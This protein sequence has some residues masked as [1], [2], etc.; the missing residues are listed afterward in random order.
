VHRY[1]LTTYRCTNAITKKLLFFLL[2]IIF[3]IPN[4]SFGYNTV[5]YDYVYEGRTGNN[6]L[7]DFVRQGI[8]ESSFNSS[9][10]IVEANRGKNF[11]FAIIQSIK[12]ESLPAVL[13]NIER[14]DLFKNYHLYT[15]ANY[16]NY[17]RNLCGYEEF[18]IDL[19]D[20]I[21]D[22]RNNHS[23]R[24]SLRW[25]TG[26]NGKT[27]FQD[28]IDQEYEK[29]CKKRRDREAKK[30]ERV[31]Q[32]KLAE[33]KFAEMNSSA[34]FR[35]LKL[36][37]LDELNNLYDE[38]E[39]N[40][41]Q[42]SLSFDSHN[43]YKPRL[44]AL[45]KTLDQDCKQFDY[46]K[47]VEKHNF[48]DSN[49]E[50]FDYCYGTMLDKQL[51]EELCS[52]RTSAMDLQK[53][54]SD[55]K[56]AYI[57]S[58]TVLH[59]TAVAK[60]QQSANVAFHLSD[61]SYYFLKASETLVDG[62][63]IGGERFLNTFIHP[64]DKFLKPL[65]LS[66]LALG[67]AVLGVALN[68]ADDPFTLESPI[69]IVKKVKDLSCDFAQRV[70]ENPKE[71]VASLVE[72]FLL[73]RI[74]KFAKLLNVSKIFQFRK[75]KEFGKFVEPIQRVLCE[76]GE[77]LKIGLE[78]GRKALKNV[79]RVIKGEPELVSV[80]DIAVLRVSGEHYKDFEKLSKSV[81]GGGSVNKTCGLGSYLAREAG[82]SKKLMK[83][84]SKHIP[85]DF[86]KQVV[87]MSKKD[88]IT[89]L[90]KQSFFNPNWTKEEIITG[91]TQGYLF[92]KNN[93]LTGSYKHKFKGEY[94]NIFVKPNGLIDTAFGYHKLS[95]D[96]FLK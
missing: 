51:H 31:R 54:H 15:C 14:K 18:I 1:V 8:I 56:Q 46:S 96:Y 28:F 48:T 77:V 79:V 80:S 7:Q 82:L 78:H 83:H 44:D 92:M 6:S 5:H 41:I 53:K 25:M 21:H 88:L 19:H 71:A 20:R 45:R 61:F 87:Y 76:A 66:G 50:Y 36:D 58:E 27:G 32:Q 13:S 62:A 30:Q 69:E 95:L 3:I 91:I 23:F 11:D 90:E 38:W 4:R 12:A 2:T 68:A 70:K 9:N 67:Q 10:A 60:V 75:C 81:K 52:I 57:L 22:N 64:V 47:H 84:I 73:G 24:K 72:C 40:N 59:F 35:I 93:G 74:D 55:D 39:D 49:A 26:F 86:S 34:L 63:V 94:I 29:I 37:N 33:E 17:I 16:L 65:C 85:D 42:E 43:Y 89:K